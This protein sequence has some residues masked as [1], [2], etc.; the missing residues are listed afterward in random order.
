MWSRQF[1]A[2]TG[3]NQEQFTAA[4]LKALKDQEVAKTMQ[5]IICGELQKELSELRETIKA[6]D[7]KILAL[8]KRLI[9]TELKVDNL[10]QYSRRNSL[11]IHGLVENTTGHED[12]EQVVMDLFQNKLGVDIE[13]SGIDRIHR[14][15]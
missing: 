4:F 9:D 15:G 6:K 8:E 11:R 13:M 14:I 7:D 5:T 2:K 3:M 1:S 12:T 10:E